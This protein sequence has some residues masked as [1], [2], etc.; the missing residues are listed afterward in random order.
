M[1]PD[2]GPRLRAQIAVLRKAGTPEPRGSHGPVTRSPS[3]Q[4]SSVDPHAQQIVRDGVLEV[5]LFPAPESVRLAV[6]DIHVRDAV[7]ALKKASA[8]AA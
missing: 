2:Y 6:D 1:G 3:G 8:S 4:W 7:R 5:V